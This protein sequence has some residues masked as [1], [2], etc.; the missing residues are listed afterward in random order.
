VSHVGLEVLS[1]CLKG[2]AQAEIAEQLGLKP[3]QVACRSKE[4][5]NRVTT[6]LALY[7]REL[8]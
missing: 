2:F 7:E 6:A 1:F 4:L 5:K 8:E 3:G